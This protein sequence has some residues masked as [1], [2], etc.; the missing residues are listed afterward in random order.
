MEENEITTDSITSCDAYLTDE[1]L[2]SAYSS[3]DSKNSI[4]YMI[5]I[6]FG[7][8]LLTYN[9]CLKRWISAVVFALYLAFMVCCFAYSRTGLVKKWIAEYRFRSHGENVHIDFFDT[10]L[11]DSDSHSSHKYEYNSFYKAVEL[12]SLWLVF[13]GCKEYPGFLMIPK[14]G[15]SDEKGYDFFL[16]NVIDRIEQNQV[17]R[18]KNKAGKEATSAE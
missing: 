3:A 6:A 7:L 15:Y 18:L 16:E 14:T 12:P 2:K 4:V 1:Q 9:L 8:G 5:F 17:K 13:R 11:V 10:Y